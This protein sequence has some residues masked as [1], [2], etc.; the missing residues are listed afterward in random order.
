MAT[1]SLAIKYRPQTFDDVVEQGAVKTI[2]T[3]QLA[4]GEVKHAYLFC[5]WC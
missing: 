1:K 3:Q 5:G 2:L 4:S